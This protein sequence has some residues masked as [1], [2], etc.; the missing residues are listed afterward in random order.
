VTYSN[1]DTTVCNF[2]LTPKALRIYDKIMST[3]NSELI[4]NLLWLLSH[5][6]DYPSCREQLLNSNVF[7]KVVN[8]LMTGEAL[9]TLLI[10]NGIWLIS[11]LSK[12]FTGQMQSNEKVK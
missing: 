12:D 1:V 7:E 4:Y 11:T 2:F 10:R 8:L 9:H 5:V 6:G 3:Q